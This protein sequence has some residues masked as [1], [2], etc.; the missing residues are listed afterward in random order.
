MNDIL[1]KIK[2]AKDLGSV[3]VEVKEWGVTFLIKEP[4][5]KR[6]DELRKQYDLD[7]EVDEKGNAKIG[8]DKAKATEDFGL[9]C[10]VETIHDTEGNRVFENIEQAEEVLG[11]KSAKVQKKLIMAVQDLLKGPTVEEAE[12]NS[13]GTQSRPSSIG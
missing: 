11:E 7:V 3:T 12:G 6:I 9:A 4:T 10:I 13:D 8:T 2:D 5:R 1:Q